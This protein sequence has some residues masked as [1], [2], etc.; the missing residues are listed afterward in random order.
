[1]DYPSTAYYLT[2]RPAV[3]TL[4]ERRRL[5]GTIINV[6]SQFAI[7]DSTARP[8]ARWAP[9]PSPYIRLPPAEA[10]LRG[11]GAHPPAAAN[12][13]RR[14][15]WGQRMG[16]RAGGISTRERI[17]WWMCCR[18]AGTTSAPERIGNG[19]EKEDK[20][21][22]CFAFLS[23]AGVKFHDPGKPRR[24]GV[25]G[26]WTFRG[27]IWP[28]PYPRHFVEQLPRAAKISKPGLAP[29]RLTASHPVSPTGREP[30]RERVGGAGPGRT[31]EWP[32][33]EFS[34]TVTAGLDPSVQRRYFM[35]I[36]L[37]C[38]GGI[39]RTSSEGVPG[40][41]MVDANVK[42]Q[43]EWWDCHMQRYLRQAVATFITTQES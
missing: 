10:P 32:N 36:Q 27:I 30:R 41:R 18:G 3:T 43:M 23:G 21:R 37:A 6:P 1:Q 40:D 29:R 20:A 38:S 39:K 26:G 8:Y 13:E 17:M 2:N 42:V 22:N 35:V 15:G 28:I 11:R 19:G 34:V 7:S 16:P 14:D 25:E 24:R 31:V 9:P 33:A 12:R 5:G 4:R